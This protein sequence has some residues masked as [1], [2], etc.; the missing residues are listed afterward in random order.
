MKYTQLDIA[1][2]SLSRLEAYADNYKDEISIPSEFK[3]I[4]ATGGIAELQEKKRN[5]LATELQKL[6]NKFDKEAGTG[7]VNK[8]SYGSSGSMFCICC[9]CKQKKF[10]RPDVYDQRVKKFGSEEALKKGYKCMVCRK[11]DSLAKE[12]L[13][14]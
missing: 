2:Y 10:A 13:G 8:Q 5:F 11:I 9:V 4:S 12:V 7:E 6:S 1:D 3:G 14:K